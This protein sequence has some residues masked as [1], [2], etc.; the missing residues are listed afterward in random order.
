MA[1]CYGLSFSRPSLPHSCRSSPYSSSSM[2]AKSFTLCTNLNHRVQLSNLF[3]CQ[4]SVPLRELLQWK[5]VVGRGTGFVECGSARQLP[6]NVLGRRRMGRMRGSK[7]AFGGNLI[8]PAVCLVFDDMDPENLQN[9]I[10]GASV[11]AATSASLYYGLKV[12][13]LP[14]RMLNRILRE[15]LEFFM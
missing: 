2:S 8:E 12:N 10:V 1:F 11:L 15:L 9:L 7:L 14:P 5:F 6:E 4:S 13:H 3:P